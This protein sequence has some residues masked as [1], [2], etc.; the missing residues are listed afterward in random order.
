M[1]KKLFE[2]Y[3]NKAKKDH[4][5]LGKNQL[6]QFAVLVSLVELDGEY[7]FLFEKRASNI[8]QGGEISFPGGGYEAGDVS[9]EA[10]AIRETC[11]ELGL[12]AEQIEIITQVDT[13]VS[14]VYIENYLGLIKIDSLEELQINKDEV[15]Y[16]FTLPVQYFIDKQPEIYGIKVR[17]FSSETDEKGNIIEYMPVEALDLP[18]RYHKSW[19]E[20]EREVYVYRTP[21]G[22]LWGITALIVYDTLYNYLDILPSKEAAGDDHE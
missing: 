15:D 19:S 14:H 7:H 6:K 5:I 21:Y 20:R 1:K 22:T 3:L 2:P 17:S 16:V 13:F 9:F 8:R 10:T 4:H 12:K 18:K 11:E